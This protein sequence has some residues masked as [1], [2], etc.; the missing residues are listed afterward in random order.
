MVKKRLKLLLVD[1]DG[2]MSNGRFYTSLD[3]KENALGNAAAG[4][5]FTP[6][7]KA[8]VNKWMRGQVT[9][10]EIHDM[11]EATHG[12]NARQLDTLLEK[13][14]ERMPINQ[15]MLDFVGFVRSKGVSVSLFTNNMDIFDMVLRRYHRLDEHFD[16]IYSSSQYGQL[17]LE[18][19]ALIMKAL[20]DAGTKT[21]DEAVLVD[22]SQD[23][24]DLA[25]GYGLDAFLYKRYT[26]SQNQFETW[27][28]Q[29]YRL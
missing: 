16:H 13:S 8:L 10:P 27:L 11:I 17:K 18:N 29:E 21:I 24:Y 9:Y 15:L 12:L 20:K 19:D 4:I 22:D 1:F 7:N 5:I 14:I 23:S 2:V 25:K 6:E 26:D 3:Q 28:R